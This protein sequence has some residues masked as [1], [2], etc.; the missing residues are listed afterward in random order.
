MVIDGFKL[1]QSYKFYHYAQTNKIKLFQLPSHSNYFIQP[2]D[3]GG[4]Q[5]FKLHHIERLKE[6]L[7]DR[8]I[9]IDKLD[10]LAVFYQMCEKDFIK[11][12][13]LSK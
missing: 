5:P 8:E 7:W 13:I 6:S 3:V 11:L 4:F 2:L 10:F 12:T 1:H 9:D